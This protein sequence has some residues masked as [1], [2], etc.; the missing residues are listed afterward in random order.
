MYNENTIF[1]GVYSEI[2]KLSFKDYAWV[3]T[4]RDRADD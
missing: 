1:P 2:G 3:Y 4:A